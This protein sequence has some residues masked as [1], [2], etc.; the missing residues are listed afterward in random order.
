MD[1]PNGCTS[2]VDMDA[3]Y[4]MQTPKTLALAE[5]LMW[6]GS[7]GVTGLAG[8]SNR[9][10]NMVHNHQTTLGKHGYNVKGVDKYQLGLKFL[11][12]GGHIRK[13]MELYVVAEPEIKSPMD[14]PGRLANLL[15]EVPNSIPAA[16]SNSRAAFCIHSA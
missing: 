9:G 3:K 1:M 8:G 2:Y 7:C 12:V 6:R 13:S 16:V 5:E 14:E 10:K 11:E 15:V 4:P